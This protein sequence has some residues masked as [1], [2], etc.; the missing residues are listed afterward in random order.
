MLRIVITIF[1]TKTNISLAILGQS[2]IRLSDRPTELP[3]ELSPESASLSP[4]T[5]TM[6]FV[7]ETTGINVSFRSWN[8]PTCLHPPIVKPSM[9]VCTIRLK[10]LDAMRQ[11]GGGGGNSKLVIDFP[12]TPLPISRAFRI[13]PRELE[14][15]RRNGERSR[16]T[17]TR[18]FRLR[19][20]ESYRHPLCNRGV[21]SIHRRL[22]FAD[23]KI[24]KSWIVARGFWV[25]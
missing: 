5:K 17:E 10:T 7:H 15:Y 12:G 18:N 21:G 11:R 19:D 13:P 4:F 23:L 9:T 22:I 3:P 20:P 14:V 24:E 8:C 16:E 2:Q 1:V 25:G 6:S